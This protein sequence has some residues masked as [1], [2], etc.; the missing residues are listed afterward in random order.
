MPGTGPS[1]D[2]PTRHRPSRAT[3]PK[4]RPRNPH[5]RLL[6]HQPPSHRTSRS[7]VPPKGNSTYRPKPSR[8]AAKP[9]PTGHARPPT[10]SRLELRSLFLL[11]P[12]LPSYAK[13]KP[14]SKATCS[15]NQVSVLV[16]GQEGSD[17][18]AV[19]MARCNV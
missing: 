1:T 11:L 16:S 17:S 18:L 13:V 9:A 2:R 4:R 3:Y 8:S 14:L 5:M 19:H 15:P 12:F 10:L 7:R 6:P